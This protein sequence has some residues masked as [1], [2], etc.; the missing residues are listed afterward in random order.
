MI[1]SIHITSLTDVKNIVVDRK[2]QNIAQTPRVP[3]YLPCFETESISNYE[4]YDMTVI[5]E[6]A[7][8][9]ISLA[10]QRH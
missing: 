8:A 10:R 7:V 4:N 5:Y 6:S 1:L 3:T 2:N 9:L